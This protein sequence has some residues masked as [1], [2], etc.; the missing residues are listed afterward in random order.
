MA[1]AV[2]L[3]AILAL[4]AIFFI[5]VGAYLKG[6]SLHKRFDKQDVVSATQSKE[7]LDLGHGVKSVSE[8]G[9]EMAKTLRC[10]KDNTK[11]IIVMLRAK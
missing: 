2:S 11:E 4:V 10:I 5:S 9:K 3:I 8:S 7:M 6:N 1:D